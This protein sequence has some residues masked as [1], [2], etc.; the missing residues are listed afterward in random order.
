VKGQ[1]VTFYIHKRGLFSVF[2]TLLVLLFSL[3]FIDFIV[4]NLLLIIGFA[5]LIF[6]FRNPER[7]FRVHEQSAVMALSDGEVELIENL[8]DGFKIRVKKRFLDVGVL[9]SPFFAQVVSMTWTKGAR[10]PQKWYDAKVLNETISLELEDMKDNHRILVEIKPLP[11]AYFLTVDTQ[12]ND[13]LYDIARFGFVSAA[14]I[15]ITLPQNSRVA[16]QVG[17]SLKAGETLLAYFTE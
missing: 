15:D 17:D 11:F 12:T 1:G 14:Y 13:K 10:L 9:R 6:H 7:L 4:L 5:F 16:V 3:V 2:I 8:D